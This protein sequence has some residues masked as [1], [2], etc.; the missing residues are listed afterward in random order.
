MSDKQLVTILI[1]VH[2]EEDN[3]PLLIK[4]L[5]KTVSALPMFD[6]EALFV[7]DGSTDNTLKM[8]EQYADGGLAVGYLKLSKNFGHQA[9]LEAGLQ[10]ASG[11]IVISMDGDLQHPPEMI[12]KMLEEY[13]KG[14]DVVQMQRSNTASDFKGFLSVLSV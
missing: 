14:A 12:P 4:R 5:S 2:N 9:A 10:H 11:G 8:I 7:D 13:S 3:I 1:P 6:F